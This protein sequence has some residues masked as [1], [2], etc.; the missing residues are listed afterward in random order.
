MRSIDQARG[1][2]FSAEAVCGGGTRQSFHRA[3]EQQALV[4]KA[5][6]LEREKTELQ[7]KLRAAEEQLAPVAL[8]R[9]M[10]QVDRILTRVA[11]SQA[12]VLLTGESGVAK[13]IIARRSTSE[14]ASGRADG[15]AE[16]RAFPANMIEAELFGYGK[17]AFAGTVTAFPGMIAEANGGTLFLD[18]VTEMPVTCRPV[19]CA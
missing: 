7:V 13:E 17:D 19:F 16:L 4:E 5:V 15:G 11:P 8:G 6:A 18:E 10:R 9:R 12:N 14:C 3:L 1:I 2:S